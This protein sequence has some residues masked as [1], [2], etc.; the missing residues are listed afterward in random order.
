MYGSKGT[1]VVVVVVVVII[2]LLLIVVFACGWGGNCNGGVSCCPT[3]CTSLLS[4]SLTGFAL[5]TDLNVVNSVGID[6]NG[7]T[8][9]WVAES[10]TGVV[11]LLNGSGVT[12]K[13]VTVP[14]P[15]GTFLIHSSPAGLELNRSCN[16]TD[17]VISASGAT[18]P[19]LWL[20][21]TNEGT[22]V[23]YS[24]TVNSTSAFVQVNNNATAVYTGLSIGYQC[25]GATGDV[26]NPCVRKTVYVPRVYVAN[27]FSGFV[28]MY[29]ND[30]NFLGEFTD[31]DVTPGDVPVFAPYNVKACGN[32]VYVTF[33][34]QNPEFTA[35]VGGQGLGFVDVFRLDGTFVSRVATGGTL[36]APYGLAL[37]G[38]NMLF[39]GNN[40]DGRIS[41]F[42]LSCRCNKIC[43]CF[44][45]YVRDCR[46]FC[47]NE[48]VEIDGLNG[49]ATLGSKVYFAAGTASGAYGLIGS[50]SPCCNNNNNNNGGFGFFGGFRSC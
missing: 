29:D 26:C 30:F 24:P 14:L 36:N 1:V 2:I 47:H 32:H 25:T 31:P 48:P 35:A 34:L 42:Q 7:C 17:L 41:A 15:T 28:E 39:V 4:S 18:G 22:I 45:D 46:N 16:D 13:S 37:V 27:F 23:A 3:R 6:A 50:L 33:A 5:N 20:A 49:L 8:D 12:V 40:G 44:V 11:S 21:A 19:A 9:V 10:G 43:G 38:S